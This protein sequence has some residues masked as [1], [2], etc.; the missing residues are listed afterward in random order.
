MQ[1]KYIDHFLCETQTILHA[2]KSAVKLDLQQISGFI[3]THITVY[4]MLP[5][6]F[7]RH[8]KILLILGGLSGINTYLCG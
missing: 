1:N 8:C 2:D 3:K 6:N 7:N 5:G 4:Y